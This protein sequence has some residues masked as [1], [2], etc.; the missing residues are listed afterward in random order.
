MSRTAHTDPLAPLADALAAMILPR[1]L[2]AL[3]ER[4]AGPALLAVHST[5]GVTRRHAAEICRAGRVPGAVIIG[6][7]WRSPQSGI[8]A[9]LASL[10]GAR[11]TQPT[12]DGEDATADDVLRSLGCRP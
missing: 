7:M 11:R 2:A 3:A 12:D 10:R 4:E 6:R 9:Y 1:V 8:D 5:L